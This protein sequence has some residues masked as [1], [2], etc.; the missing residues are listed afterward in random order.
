MNYGMIFVSINSLLHFMKRFLFLLLVVIPCFSYAQPP[1]P[2]LWGT[3]IHDEAG[4]LPAPFINQIELQLKQHED[5]TSNQIALLV[6]ETLDGYPIEQ[7][8]LAVAEKW[9]LGQKKNDNGILVFVAVK[10]HKIRIEVGSGL[11]GVLPDLLAN[12]IIRNEMAPYFRKSDY[13]GGIQ[14]GMNA[15]IKAIAGEYQA[16]RSTPGG[17]GGGVSMV[18]L[19][20]VMIV[21]ILISRMRGGRGG[22]R[23]GG[24]W[25]SG[26]GWFGGSG[27][28]GGSGGGGFGGGGFSGGGGGFGGG[29]SSGSW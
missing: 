22:G 5:S 28:S 17:G 20:V 11:E 13:E 9:L 29:G 26:P 10:D 6:I 18:P 12:Q 19:I 23:R 25:S 3:R 15:I 24:G 1:I 8:T 14:A 16:D 27:W 7:Y 21:I 4:I 2:E